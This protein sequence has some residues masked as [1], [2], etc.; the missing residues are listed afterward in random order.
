M[1]RARRPKMPM[2]GFASQLNDIEI[3]NLIQ[4]LDA[5]A[6]AR[7]ALAMTDRV[8]P[9]RPVFA[10]DF[11][12]EIIGRAQESLERQRKNPVALLVFYTLPQSLPRLRE[13]ANKQR[14]I[15]AAGARVIAVPI[16][17]SV[18]AGDA[19]VT[20]DGESIFA[21]ASRNIAHVYAMFTRQ[22]DGSKIAA[23]THV[24]FLV[25]RDGYLRVRWIGVPDA[26]ADRMA[27]TLVGSDCWSTNPRVNRCNGDTDTD[28][29]R[30]LY[31]LSSS[32]LRDVRCRSTTSYPTSSAAPP[33][34]STQAAVAIEAPRWITLS[35]TATPIST[36]KPRARCE[37]LACCQSCPT[38]TPTAATTIIATLDASRESRPAPE[39]EPTHRRRYGR[40]HATR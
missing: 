40:A 4:F 11:T 33:L 27:A 9:L 7:N 35:A 15:L 19:Q 28:R 14:A 39:T 16:G 31:G 3:W 6:E 37:K 18:I 26:T 25:D 1:D 13:L 8:K 5:Q 32:D 36:S 10:P 29:A 24:E 21:I 12:F 34:C 20:T 22:A 23:Y 2:P 17:E 38:K 30:N